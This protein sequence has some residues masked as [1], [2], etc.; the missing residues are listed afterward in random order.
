MGQYL[1]GTVWVKKKLQ[2]KESSREKVGW[3]CR[4]EYARKVKTLIQQL[5]PEF[6]FE[7][8]D[9]STQTVR[10]SSHAVEDETQR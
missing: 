2:R 3:T 7:V 4:N 9:I 8:S 10:S 5:N 6:I 1:M